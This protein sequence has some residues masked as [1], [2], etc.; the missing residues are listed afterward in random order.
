[1]HLSNITFSMKTVIVTGANSGLGLWTS[2]HLLDRN[3][4]VIMACRNTVKAAADI[5][6]FGLLDK[7]QAHEI[8]PLDLA[9]F[10][11]IRHF[12][13]ELPANEN[14]YGLVCN[15]GISYEGEFRY[16]KNGYE[17][18]FGT[19][20]LG[21][22]LLSNLLLEKYKIERIA[23]VASE[24]HDPNNKSPFAKAGFNTVEDLAHPKVDP[25]STLNKQC[26]TFYANSK[27]CNIL[28]TYE[29]ERRLLKKNLPYPVLVNTMN[30]GLMLST[31][32]GRTHKSGEKF[33]RQLMDGFFRL[34]GLGDTPEHSA[35]VVADLIDKTSVSGKYFNKGKVVNSSEE[36]YNTQKAL[37]LWHYSED[38]VGRKFL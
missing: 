7:R 14:I 1:M 12:V 28:F 9:D 16:T 33:S 21:H 29:L 38:A 5:E 37:A 23:I 20:H 4:R 34:I 19:N 25:N 17:A 10:E 22:F 27:L 31:N 11:S 15:A 2:K 32:L 18:S 24:L 3:Y 13:N 26:Q 6:R 30:P 36:S 35:M 8:R